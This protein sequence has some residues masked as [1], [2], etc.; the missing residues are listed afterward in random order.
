VL[1]AGGS[2]AG[3]STDTAKT[4]AELYD[5]KTG[6]WSGTGSLKAA[7]STATLLPSGKVLKTGDGIAELYDP[8][9]GA[10][11]SCPAETAS[12]SCPAPTNEHGTTATLLKNGKV[13]LVGG[14]DSSEGTEL[15]DP[16]K[17]TWTVTGNLNQ[18]RSLHTAT[19]LASGKVLVTGGT[20]PVGLCPGELSEPKFSS[21]LY[22]PATGTWSSCQVA[23]NADCP[24]NLNEG[25]AE[26]TATLLP[27][28]KV[29]VAGGAS[30]DEMRKRAEL[31]D[32]STGDWSFTRTLDDGRT[33]H[34]AALLPDR[35]TLVSGGGGPDFQNVL[36]SAELF[37]FPA[38]E[39]LDLPAP[40]P[41]WLSAERMSGVRGVSYGEKLQAVVL[42]SDTDTFG[43]DAGVCGNNCGKVLMIGGQTTPDYSANSLA[44]TELYTPDPTITDIAPRTGAKT[45]GTA[46]KIRGTGFSHKVSEVLFGDTPATSF[47]VDSYSQITAVSPASSTLA[48]VPVSVINEGGKARSSDTFAYTP[49]TG[50]GGGAPGED[51]P[52]DGETTPGDGETTP[53]DGETTP[54]DGGGTSAGGQAPGGQAPGGQAPAPGGG[55]PGGGAPAGDGAAGGE[56]A[57]LVHPAKLEVARSRVLRR[58]R[59]VDVL[60]PITKRAS[61]KA[62]VDFHAAR[63]HTRFEVAVD[64]DNGRLRFKKGIPRA[65]AN[66]GTGILTLRYP[67]D[68][69]TR[70]QEVRLRAASQKAKLELERPR[71]EDGRI[72]AQGTISKRARGVVRL[73]VQYVVAGQTETVKLRGRIDEGRWKIDEALSTDVLLGLLAREGPVHSYTLFTGYYPRR[74]RGEMQSYQV[75]FG[76]GD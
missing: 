21:E 46:V 8:A 66:L 12:A 53:G 57:G 1:V 38:P 14:G 4:S 3:G 50:D 5:P 43:A 33:G 58:D 63:R 18:G 55:P 61:G 9:A 72:K 16:A 75:A 29:L 37:E 54:G 7:S 56:P 17:G 2:T 74:I 34:G 6:V 24:G 49:A 25:R 48:S 19:L 10:W 27:D 65:Q 36:D 69:D 60:A 41:P 52:G 45:G 32:P 70:P 26:H 64:E 35:R 71:I 22:D 62:S 39:R 31:Y 15:Y 73:Q 76:P 11:S 47:R 23:P 30:N 68:E 51:D 59:A 13:L 67:G 20:C 44:S 42:S 40:T 28:G